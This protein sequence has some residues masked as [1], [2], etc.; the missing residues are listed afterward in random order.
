MLRTLQHLKRYAGFRV[1]I[2]KYSLAFIN[3]EERYVEDTAASQKI[4]FYKFVGGEEGNFWSLL[5]DFVFTGAI[6]K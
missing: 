3:L 6:Y 2:W 4:R 5:T 1:G